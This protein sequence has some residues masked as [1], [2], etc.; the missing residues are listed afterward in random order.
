MV[1]HLRPPE[2][3]F[4]RR[5]RH[6]LLSPRW[7]PGSS[8]FHGVTWS[9]PVNGHILAQLGVIITPINGV[10]GPLLIAAFF[11]PT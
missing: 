9:A 5:L 6:R 8:D 1:Y 3:I 7:A 2:T 11:G 4:A 10:M